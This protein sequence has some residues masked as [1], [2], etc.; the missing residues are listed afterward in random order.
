MAVIKLGML[1]FNSN[2]SVL[3]NINNNVERE[4]I[5]NRLFIFDKLKK[6]NVFEMNCTKKLNPLAYFV[7]DDITSEKD[8][9]GDVAPYTKIVQQTEEKLM[10]KGEPIVYNGDLTSD[11][12][13]TEQAEKIDLSLANHIKR[14]QTKAYKRTRP[15]TLELCKV[16]FSKAKRKLDFDTIYTID[17][18]PEPSTSKTHQKEAEEETTEI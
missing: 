14:K 13:D 10:Y 16:D 2:V 4:A 18:S 15:E 1:L 8:F 5:K 12:S 7:I 6:T 17:S 3:S 11:I 9:H